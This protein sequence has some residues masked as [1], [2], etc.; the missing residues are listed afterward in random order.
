MLT[1]DRINEGAADGPIFFNPGTLNSWR[2][3]QIFGKMW[4]YRWE[5]RTVEIESPEGRRYDTRSWVI[6]EISEIEYREWERDPFD[7]P[8]VMAKDVDDYIREKIMR[9]VQARKAGAGIGK[10]CAA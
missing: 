7:Q 4:R 2:E 6:L 1:D 5:G 10:K 8:M 9:S 3:L